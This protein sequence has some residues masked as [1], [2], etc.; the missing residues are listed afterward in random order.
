LLTPQVAT[1]LIEDEGKEFDLVIFENAQN[2]D[3][4]QVVPILRN[5]EGVV[6]MNE[7]AYLDALPAHSFAAKVKENGAAVV[8][9][10]YLH[11]SLSDTTRRL[12]Q[13]VF[14][15]NV[16][17]P[18]RQATAEQSVSVHFLDGK[19]SDKTRVNEFEIA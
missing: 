1:Q 7:T 11:R 15:P 6:V 14:Y 4:E 12:N 18:Y 3:T 2:L 16:Q 17:V 13:S 19:F 10:N 9:L 5:T 8:T